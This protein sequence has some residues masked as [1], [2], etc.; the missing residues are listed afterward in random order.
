MI[1][2]AMLT[3]KNDSH[4]VTLSGH[5][6]LQPEAVIAFQA[7]QRAAEKDGFN[8][9][10][11]ST[12]RDFNRQRLIWNGKFSG[13]RPVMD[14][15]GRPL[16]ILSLDEGD[17]C[18]A[19]LRWSAMPGA[20]RHH[21]GSDLDIYDPDRLPSGQKLQLEPWEYQQGGYF[22]DLNDWLSEHMHEFGFY[23]PYEHDLGGVAAE[24]WHISYYPL[25]QYAEKQLTSGIILSAWQ[26]EEIAGYH[27]LCEHLPQLFTRFI[28]N[29][30]GA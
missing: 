30:D 27:W 18:K 12:F 17:R 7:L 19:I 25:A 10:P 5:H 22:A 14:K 26:G 29:V 11:A 16:D 13:E 21:W 24:P 15:Q 23:R 1:T 9:Q 8:L 4:L 28:H 2:H 6:R 3:G 20:S